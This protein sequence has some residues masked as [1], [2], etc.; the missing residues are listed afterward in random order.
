MACAGGVGVRERARER[1]GQYGGACDARCDD[2]ENEDGSLRR[3]VRVR[4]ARCAR[5]CV[6]A[7]V[8]V[9]VRACGS[10]GRQR[11]RRDIRKRAQRCAHARLARRPLRTPQRWH[12]ARCA[13]VAWRIGRVQLDPA[14]ASA[15][16]WR[17]RKQ[18]P[19]PRQPV[20]AQLK[21][22]DRLGGPPLEARL[23]QTF[24]PGVKCGKRCD[25]GRVVRLPAPRALRRQRQRRVRAGR[26]AGGV[27][28][29]RGA[30][31][32]QRRS[33]VESGRVEREA[34][35]ADLKAFFLD[36]ALA[37][38]DGR[39]ACARDAA[40][41]QRGVQRRAHAEKGSV[42][43][44]VP[45]ASESQT[46]AH[47]LSTALHAQ[48]VGGSAAGASTAGEASAAAR[49]ECE[50]RRGT[51]CAGGRCGACSAAEREVARTRGG[52]AAACGSA[53]LSI[54]ARRQECRRIVPTGRQFAAATRR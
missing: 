51:A 23:E 40:S 53:G 49:G 28:E 14:G 10:R 15:V 32:Q 31:L 41:A 20:H 42:W 33:A 44:C 7:C 21:H 25:D 3:R 8:C 34:A 50:R 46:D 35:R 11:Q 1:G 47:S 6:R 24:R 19:L 39:L 17:A 2:D 27:R 16:L 5:A 9:C 30:R 54:A 4:A 13:D 26:H 29:A 52:A 43:A 37:Q 45:A 48:S 22:R 38:Q 12:R 18:V 36:A